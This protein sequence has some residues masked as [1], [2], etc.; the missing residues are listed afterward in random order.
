MADSDG[1]TVL[2]S[3]GPEDR[4]SLYMTSYRS[5]LGSLI[6]ILGLLLLITQACHITQGKSTIFCNDKDTLRNVFKPALDARNYPLVA[7]DYDLLGITR[8][9]L[10]QLPITVKHEWAKSHYTGTNQ[11]P[12]HDLNNKANLFTTT[13]RN[14]LHPQFIP[15][16][17]PPFA[18]VQIVMVQTNNTTMTSKLSTT[19]YFNIYS[20]LIPNTICK[21]SGLTPTTSNCIDWDNHTSAIPFCHVPKDRH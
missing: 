8:D 14:A 18:D 15:A 21:S 6:T 17:Q 10:K 3:A 16:S 2:C 19:I 12:T 7:S 9:L 4:G 13:Y 11:Q 5:K 1:N 20:P